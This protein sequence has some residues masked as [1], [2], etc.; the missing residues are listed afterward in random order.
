MQ[1][2]HDGEDGLDPPEAARLLEQANRD[3]HRKLDVQPLLATAAGGLAVLVGYGGLWWSVRDQQ[4][5]TGPALGAIILMYGVIAGSV[6]VTATL[7]RRATA[8]VSGPTTRVRRVEGVALLLSILASPLIQ[9]ALKHYGA[10]DSI[11]YGVIPAAAPLIIIGSTAMGIAA[12][13]DNR[14]QFGAALVAV[15]G[16]IVALWM[17]P[18]AAW[19]VAGIG[20]FTGIAGYAAAGL[21]HR[22][23]KA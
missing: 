8:G 7:Y 13:H 1:G 14:R 12:S 21:R 2:T 9:G 23:D 19:A 22:L 15:V 16:G 3:A 18:H 20:L 4:P 11:V 5:Y 6:V 10:S 17:G